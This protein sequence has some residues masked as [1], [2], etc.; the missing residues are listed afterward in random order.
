MNL[1]APVKEPAFACARFAAAVFL[2][3]N[4]LIVRL[5]RVKKIEIDVT[6]AKAAFYPR[7]VF[8]IVNGFRDFLPAPR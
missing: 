2:A 5:N 8:A 6:A 4:R 7:V 1:H 3:G